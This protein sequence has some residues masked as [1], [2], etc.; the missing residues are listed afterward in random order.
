MA[1][2][3]CTKAQVKARLFPN[4]VTDTNDDTLID[5]IIE[6]VSA[7]IQG[8]TGRK[9]VAETAVTY[10]FDTQAGYVLRIPRGIRAITSM[11]VASSH[12]PD[13]AGTYTTIPAAERLLRPLTAD[14]PEGW[15]PTE[16]RLSRAATTVTHFSNAENGAT[17]TGNFGFATTPKDIEAVAIDAT[18]A[19][20][21][22]RKNGAS[23]AMGADDSP[24]PPWAKFFG[25]GSPQRATLDR[26]RWVTV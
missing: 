7:W 9:F 19:A 20:Y 13:T 1:D 21:A 12:Q 24:L 17:I 14:S 11:G 4:G 22:S 2:Q 6:E 8:Y 16:V 3:L 18:V 10:T 26:Y 5:E 15:P 25:R 23:S